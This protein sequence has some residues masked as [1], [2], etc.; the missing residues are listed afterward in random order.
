MADPPRY[1]EASDDTGAGADPESTGT[2]RWV[3]VSGIVVLALVI[4]FVI[5]TVTGGG[6]HGPG[7]H[8]LFDGGPGG[9]TLPSSVTQHDVLGR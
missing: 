8:A 2:P 9:Q 5:V 3:K 6:G 7:R 4:L 1:P